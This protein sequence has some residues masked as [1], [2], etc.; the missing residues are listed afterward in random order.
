MR[1]L[2][3]TA[4]LMVAAAILLVTPGTAPADPADAAAASAFGTTI[5]GGGEDIVPPTPQ[6]SAAIGEESTETLVDVP[7]EPLAVSGTLT[8]TALAHEAS[9]VPTALTVNEQE[10][11]GPYNA[12][13]LGVVENLEVLVNQVDAETSLLTATVVRAEAAAACVDGSP[14]YTANSEIVDLQIAGEQVPLNAPLEQVIDGVNDVL[15]QTTLNQVVDIERNVVTQ[16]PAGGIAVDA[17]VVTLLSAAG[18]A[19]LAQVRI[20][21]GEVGP[22]ACA[23]PPTETAPETVPPPAPAPDVATPALPRTG[24][25]AGSLAAGGLALGL[26]AAGITWLRRRL[27]V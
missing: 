15:E 13:G 7:A 10:V 6:V 2:R 27:T 9:D 22:I 8:A 4:A 26:S 5:T 25:D 18:D 1:A 24:T 3:I 23:A 11:A 20:A 21:H 12:T 19:P 14:E 16:N 17:L